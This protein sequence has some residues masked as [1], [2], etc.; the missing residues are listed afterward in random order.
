M[1]ESDSLKPSEADP[2]QLALDRTAARVL[3]G[4]AGPAYRTAT[5]LKLR[6]DPAPARAAIQAEVDLLS[7][8]GRDLIDGFLLFNTQTRATSKAEYLRRPD[9]G[10]KLDEYSC[11]QIRARC[12]TERDFQ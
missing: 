5:W 7:G 11:K 1:A 6:E 12:P 2:V 9:L 4:R 10:R 8:L 3:V